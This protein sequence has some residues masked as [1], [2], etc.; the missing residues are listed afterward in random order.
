MIENEAYHRVEQ[1]PYTQ[2]LTLVEIEHPMFLRLVCV[3]TISP[4][5]QEDTLQL[6]DGD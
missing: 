6:P 2:R 1:V 5:H 3:T 4:E